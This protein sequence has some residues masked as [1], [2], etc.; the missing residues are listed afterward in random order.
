MAQPEISIILHI[1]DNIY[2]SLTDLQ[3]DIKPPGDCFGSSGNS[4]SNLQECYCIQISCDVIGQLT[5]Y[6]TL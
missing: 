6:H 5:I 3:S 2:F 4:C 1:H